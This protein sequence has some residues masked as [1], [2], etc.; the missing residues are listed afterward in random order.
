MPLSWARHR[1]ET[2]LEQYLADP[3][4]ASALAS[5]AV[6][7]ASHELH[8]VLKALALSL[9]PF[10]GF[11]GLATLQAVEVDVG[12]SGDADRGCVV[13]G[14]DGELYE[15]LLRTIPAPPEMG[16]MDQIEE[17]KELELAPS[18]YVLYAYRA[19]QELAKVHRARQEPS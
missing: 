3:W 1:R 14:P 13:V 7:R 17:F 19:I 6:E 12:Y 15:L 5:A 10:P 11:L 4:R 18:E 2:L 9:D 8:D 16:G